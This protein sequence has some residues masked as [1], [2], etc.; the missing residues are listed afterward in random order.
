MSEMSDQT[1]L[2][3]LPA[4][5]HAHHTR[6]MAHVD[7]L[8]LLAGMLASADRDSFTSE[9]EIEC[10]FI[11]TQLVPHIEAIENNLYVELDRLMDHRHSMDPMRE[12][13]ARLRHLFAALCHYRQAIETSQ[14]SADDTVALRRV[15]FRLYSLL[16]VHLAEEEMYLAVID[17][18]LSAEEKDGLARAMDHAASQPV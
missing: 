7:R 3:S 16:K 13:H 14:F 6:I 17:R 1:K 5:T 4:T 9:F 10:E 18:D 12:E 8:P 2:R 15:L 11:S